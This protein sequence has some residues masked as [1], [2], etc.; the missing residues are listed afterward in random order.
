MRTS[1]MNWIMKIL[2]G[3]TA[4][5]L[6][7][8]ILSVYTLTALKPFQ[9][10]TQ[11][12]INGAEITDE[13]TLCFLAPGMAFTTAPATWMDHAI[14]HNEFALHMRLRSFA[15]NQGGPAR[16]FTVSLN[17][18]VRNL[19]VG[20]AGSELFLRLRSPVTSENGLPEYRIAGVFE[21][22]DWR[23]ID[24][25]VNQQGF[26]L[27]LDG[28]T[29]LSQPLPEHS[30]KD[31]E[32]RFRV[33]LGNE[34]TSDRPWVGEVS[35]CQVQAGEQV[36]D[37]LAPGALTIP[38][39]A[40][41]R[42]SVYDLSFWL[43]QPHY[44]RD[45]MWNFLAFI[46]LGFL[47]ATWRGPR[48]SFVLAV[49]V[50]SMSSLFAEAGQAFVEYRMTSILDWVTN[51]GGAMVGAAAARGLL[52]RYARNNRGGPRGASRLSYHQSSGTNTPRL[53]HLRAADQS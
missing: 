18:S 43:R 32:R 26:E 31:W 12:L 7:L 30:L 40:H 2:C 1:L 29:V 38:L 48:G 13:G 3:R 51:T 6:S 14:E 27:L 45:L 15:P 5:V 24:L 10:R 19:T 25:M 47:L 23:D 44:V 20:Q 42:Q 17:G 28:E 53:E 35:V 41:R 4:L 52:M 34:L 39:F 8:L 49:C 21:K 46:P 9:P 33:G 50:C 22:P 16:I 36:I 11:P 37:Y